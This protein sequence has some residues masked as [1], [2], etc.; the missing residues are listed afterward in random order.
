MRRGQSGGTMAEGHDANEGFL[1]AFVKNRAHLLRGIMGASLKS[2]AIWTAALI[3][4]AWADYYGWDTAGWVAVGIL[5]GLTIRVLPFQIA[6]V[7]AAGQYAVTGSALVPTTLA[8]IIRDRDAGRPHNLEPHGDGPLGVA[9][10]VAERVWGFA[11]D[12]SPLTP[13]M[14]AGSYVLLTAPRECLALPPEP[15]VRDPQQTTIWQLK[16]RAPRNSPRRLVEDEVRVLL[17]LV[18]APHRERELAIR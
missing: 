15:V 5:V 8:P 3:L 18:A 6:I 13:F 2:A 14:L 12:A 1:R 10:R 4:L 7:F 16:E 9:M 11:F 17:P